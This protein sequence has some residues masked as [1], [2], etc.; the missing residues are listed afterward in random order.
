MRCHAAPV[1][2]AW[3]LLRDINNGVDLRL[4]FHADEL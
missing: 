4:M 2:D 1:V 3:R